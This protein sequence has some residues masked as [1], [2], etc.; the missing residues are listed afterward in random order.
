MNLLLFENRSLSLESLA[1]VLPLEIDLK[2]Q[3]GHCH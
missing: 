2:I 3:D 1:F